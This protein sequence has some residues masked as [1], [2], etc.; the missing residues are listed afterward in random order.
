MV[1]IRA[2]G[3]RMDG[4]TIG[5]V[6][7]AMRKLLGLGALVLLGAILAAT[8][9][10]GGRQATVVKLNFATYVWQPTTVTATKNIVDSWNKSHPNIQVSIVPVDVN[11]V[12]DKL[13]TSFV[14]G[15][16]ADI[17]HDEAADIAG[18]TQQ[19]YLANLTPLLPKS[20]KSSIPKAIWDTVNYGGKITGVPSLMQTYNVF[21]NM[22]ILKSAG[23]KAP[24]LADPW[25]WPEFRANA[26]KLTTSDRHGV[27]WGLRSPVAAV[28]TMALNYG[29]HFFYLENGKWTFKFGPNDQ[30]VLRQMRDMIHVDK[31][32]DPA[33]TGLSGSA[34]LPAF[35][36]GKCA[37]TVQGNFQAQGMISQSPKGFNWAMF[38][39]LKGRTQEQ[40]ANPQTYSIAQQSENK[41]EAMQFI[42]YLL[43]AQ[44]MA[45]LALG[46]WLI[47][48][49]PAAGKIAL[50][51]TKR[52]GSWRVA[53]A[54]VVHFRKGNW[55]SLAAY[56]RWK[57]EVAQPAFVQ[58]L[59]G[60]MSL[61]ELE[62]QLSSG[63]TRVRG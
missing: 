43:N 42:A 4:A 45:K 47:P 48:A 21:A 57:N 24:T 41:E 56:A 59:K 3:R 40:V 5:K 36:G 44:N 35:F 38:P 12:H 51:S 14:G 30:N 39:L 17:I 23:I 61:E 15:T 9:A 6:G 63:W 46:D 37:M 20:L 53:T 18:F 62:N 1:R 55:V 26:K 50:K 31:S 33:A 22:T 49:N 25:T 11:S 34:V 8:T 58:Y 32:V 16:A 7:F 2:H 54:S 28:Q 52:T 19:G 10:Q 27:C 29:G 60:A 13:L